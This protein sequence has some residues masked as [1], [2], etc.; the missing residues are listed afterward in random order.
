M[1]RYHII[2]CTTITGAIVVGI[3]I[4]RQYLQKTEIM[5]KESNYTK[6]PAPENNPAIPY[7]E[8]ALAIKPENKEEK[9]FFRPADELEKMMQSLYKEVGDHLNKEAD[10]YIN[11]ALFEK[12]LRTSLAN[13]WTPPW[14]NLAPTL[15][16]EECAKMPTLDLSKV[17][18]SSSIFARESMLFDEPLFTFSRLKIL[19]PCYAEL[20]ERD[21]LWEG[22]LSAYSL[23]ASGLDPAGEPN[24]VID[25][26]MGLDNLPRI[27]QLPTLQAQLEGREIL[28]VFAQL[29][30]IK[31][32]RS[33]IEGDADEAL[34]SSTP[35]FSMTTP[36]SLVNLT[37]VFMQ[38]VSLSQSAS[39]IGAISELQ[40]P[41]KLQMGQI[42]NYMDI[43]INEIE[44]FINSCQ[45]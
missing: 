42:K 23:Y 7:S 39:A 44:N 5:L 32:V 34:V 19:Y 2:L 10:D 16:R 15:T 26:M 6:V 41:K 36:I 3:F 43:S 4:W 22:V 8:P 33:Y 28:F 25:A 24:K 11:L 12:D 45:K 21:D 30:A 9:E 27:F 38:K 35:F 20:F 17:C 29:E 13:G 40:L 37:M 18:F 1:K 14:Q 31:K